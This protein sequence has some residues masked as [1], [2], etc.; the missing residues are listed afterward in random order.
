MTM[1]DTKKPTPFQA[2]LRDHPEFQTD[3]ALKVYRLYDNYERSEEAARIAM[4]EEVSEF[5]E[6]FPERATDAVRA[7]LEQFAETAVAPAPEALATTVRETFSAS[8]ETIAVEAPR[9]P[10]S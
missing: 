6:N 3:N 1:N 7:V 5:I 4:L 8:D 10:R 9:K 2:Y